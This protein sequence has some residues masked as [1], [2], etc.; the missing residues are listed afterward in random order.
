MSRTSP[1]TTERIQSGRSNV[2]RR[3]D[4]PVAAPGSTNSGVRRKRAMSA[5][6]VSGGASFT[7]SSRMVLNADCR[8][9]CTADMSAP[10]ANCPTMRNHCCPGLVS[11]SAEYVVSGTQ[12][13]VR[14]PGSNPVNPS[15]DDT[16]DRELPSGR[17]RPRAR[18]TF[19]SA[20]NRPHPERMAQHGHL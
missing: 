5:L 17:R 2:V 4:A 20:P 11:A 7:R 8:R 19:G 3:S 16:D 9:A 14:T 1:T 18:T 15:C 6:G 10:G 12:R 13:S